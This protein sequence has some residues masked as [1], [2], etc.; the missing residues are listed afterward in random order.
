MSLFFLTLNSWKRGIAILISTAEE[1]TISLPPKKSFGWYTLQPHWSRWGIRQGVCTKMAKEYRQAV[2][3]FWFIFSCKFTCIARKDGSCQIFAGIFNVKELM[4][5]S[6]HLLCSA[7]W[8]KRGSAC[9]L[10]W[11]V[12]CKGLKGAGRAALP[13]WALAELYGCVLQKCPGLYLNQDCLAFISAEAQ[14][15]Q[16]GTQPKKVL[17]LPYDES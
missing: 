8:V 12:G 4:S 9:S 10:H 14:L 15:Q 17:L 13:S 16:V 3:F 7:Q 5:P 6:C 1:V 11:S 2:G